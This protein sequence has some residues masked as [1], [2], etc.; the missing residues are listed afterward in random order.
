M[1]VIFYHFLEENA[2]K[3]YSDPEA[4]CDSDLQ[5]IKSRVRG[6]GVCGGHDVKLNLQT[7]HTILTY[8]ISVHP[9]DQ[10]TEKKEQKRKEKKV[11]EKKTAVGFNLTHKQ[12]ISKTDNLRSYMVLT[13]YAIHLLKKT[14]K[15]NKERV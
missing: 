3:Y 4:L 5:F 14:K 8:K 10:T 1:L 12:N 9:T 13:L 7:E 15:K 2:D 11:K 6:S